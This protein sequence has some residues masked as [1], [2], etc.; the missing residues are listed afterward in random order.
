MFPT[1]VRPKAAVQFINEKLWADLGADLE[2][3]VPGRPIELEYC[4]HLVDQ[5]EAQGCA[6]QVVD[7]DA[8]VV[9][10]GVDF[11]TFTPLMYPLFADYPGVGR[12]RSSWPTST[13]PAISPFGG[14]PTA[15]PSSA[16]MI[17]EIK[18]H[19]RLAVIW[20]Q[21]APGTECWQ[22]T[23]ERFYQYYADT[24]ENFE[25][26]GFPRRRV[27]PPASRPWSS[28]SPTTS[29][30]R[31][32]RR[33]T[34]ASRRRSAAVHIT[35][36]ARPVSRQI[37]MADSSTSE[38]DRGP[39]ESHGI[40]FELQGYLLDRRPLQRASSPPNGVA[41]EQAIADFGPRPRSRATPGRRSRTIV[42]IYQVANGLLADGGDLDDREAL[43]HCARHRRRLPH[44]RLPADLL[45]RQPPRVRVGLRPHRHYAAWDGTSFTIDPAIP[46]G[47]IDVR[48]LMLAVE[49]GIPRRVIP[50]SPGVT[51]R[52]RGP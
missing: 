2:N 45:R 25:F 1:W 5:N 14:C 27:R 6:N 13:R 33:S 46:D 10:I 51:G 7:A 15:F 17:A 24:I 39:A 3:G 30:A 29:T 37:Y 18:G 28:R 12:C 21:N 40:I 47:V 11:F 43:R 44:R 48:E 19:D 31:R 20:D 41:A 22:D 8:N 42:F 9:M 36:L 50:S 23:Q 49:A 34:S 4:G 38:A 32:A 26:Q 52:D 35:G 16:E